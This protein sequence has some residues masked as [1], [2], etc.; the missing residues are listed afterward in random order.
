ML[1]GFHAVKK[2]GSCTQFTLCHILTKTL[3]KT[4]QETKSVEPKKFTSGPQEEFVPPKHGWP[5][6]RTAGDT[7]GL[8]EVLLPKLH[9]VDCLLET[10]GFAI[11]KKGTQP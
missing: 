9:T 1:L 11:G 4:Q 6:S 3:I 10:W 8:R 5:L 7:G 2:S